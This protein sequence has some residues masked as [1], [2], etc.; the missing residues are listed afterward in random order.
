M[1]ALLW[2]LYVAGN[3]KRHCHHVKYPPFLPDFNQ[4]WILFTDFNESNIKFHENPS[5]GRRAD[6]SGQT[7]GRKDMA[8]LSRL[9]ERERD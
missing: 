8:R 4:I 3:N 6:T 5:S 7:D 1:R 9:R 2:R